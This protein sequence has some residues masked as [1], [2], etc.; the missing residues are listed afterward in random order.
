MK[1][2]LWIIRGVL[3]VLGC[4]SVLGVRAANTFPDKPLRLYVG[5]SPGGSV[6]VVARIFADKMKDTLGKSV[7]VEN[8]TGAGGSIAADLVTKGEPDG[9]KLLLQ[10]SGSFDS[11]II[12]KNVNY[13]ALKDFTPIAYIGG[14]PRVLAVGPSVSVDNVQDLLK[15]AKKKPES[16]RFASEGYGASSHLGLERISQMSGA[17]LLHV[18]FKGG[19]DALLAV[20]SGQA[21]VTMLT[22]TTTLPMLR[23]GKVRP[24]AVTSLKHASL[25]PAVPTLDEAGLK[26]YEQLAWFGITGPAH[27]PP[28]VV[29]ALR[30]AVFAAAAMPEVK[31]TLAKQGF[32]VDV[33]GPE[34][35]AAYMQKSAKDTR[36]VAGEA[37]IELE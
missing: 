31:E 8:R 27:M 32:D 4:L 6:D 15:V 19:P 22:L 21:D 37:H 9:Y 24:L 33:M 3:A 5:F 12:S 10:N 23:A 36:Q 26:G 11:A 29:E 16:L 34:A 14:S 2:K 17:K 20:A 7:I 1:T 30:K 28:D 25:L 35:F 18:P 13:D